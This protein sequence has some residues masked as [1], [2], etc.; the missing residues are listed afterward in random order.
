MPKTS[1]KLIGPSFLNEIESPAKIS[2]KAPSKL[3]NQKLLCYQN[4][5]VLIQQK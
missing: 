2:N 5:H 3:G 4:S 1:A